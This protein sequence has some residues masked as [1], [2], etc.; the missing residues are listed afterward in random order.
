M[1]SFAA[2]AGFLLFS[3]RVDLGAVLTGFIPNPAALFKPA[4]TLEPLITATGSAADYWTTYIADLQ[5]SRIIAAFGTAVGINM[6]FLLPY[7]LLKRGWTRASPAFTLRS[8]DGALH[9]LFDRHGFVGDV[10]RLRLPCAGCR[11]AR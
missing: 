9:P 1:I 7:T 5:R 11:C 6:T 3:G 8:G 10:G 2:A 4:P